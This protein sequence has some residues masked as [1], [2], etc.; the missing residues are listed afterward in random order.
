[1]PN[2]TCLETLSRFHKE[3]W[4]PRLMPLDTVRLEIVYSGGKEWYGSPGERRLSANNPVDLVGSGM[5]GNGAFGMSLH[6]IIAGSDVT[7][8]GEEEL[9]GRRALRYDFRLPRLL[10]ALSITLRGGQ[11]TVGEEGT[12]WVDPDSLDVIRLESHVSEIPAFLPLRQAESTVT[13]ARTRIGNSGALLAQHATLHMIESSGSEGYDRLDFTHCR[14]FAIE[15]AI[16]FETEGETSAAPAAIG[17]NAKPPADPVDAVPAFLPVT[18]LLAT[19]ISDETAV[20]TLIEAK[21]SGAVRHKGKVVIADGARAGGRVRR[22]ER[23]EPT[24]VRQFLVGLEFTEVDTATGPLRFY[25]DF[26]RI[27]KNARIRPAT[28]RVPVP[29]VV[30]NREQ[31]IVLPDLPGVAS[32]FVS[33]KSFTIPAGFR[34]MW[35]TRG[36]IR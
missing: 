16:H 7:Y 35:R 20:G 29:T 12:F 5:I 10:K 3:T 26:L 36:L 31:V 2:Y 28:E 17:A 24:G 18:L 33:G 34:M 19:P 14:T 30:P 4:M 11:G 27:D 22:L 1:M 32:F 23:F 25:A 6:N 13:Y 21:V 8:R 15:S 9:R